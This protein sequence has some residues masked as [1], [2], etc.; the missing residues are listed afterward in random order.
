ML[1][2]HEAAEPGAHSE[3][4]RIRDVVYIGMVTRYTVELD[5]GGV[6]M[7]TRQNLETTSSEVLEARGRRVRLAWRPEHTYVIETG[8]EEEQDE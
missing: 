5:E 3:T 1:E 6:L 2:E 4:G 7:V 8:D